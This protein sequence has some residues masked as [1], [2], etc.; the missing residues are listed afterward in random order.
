MGIALLRWYLV[1]WDGNKWV[2]NKATKKAFLKAIEDSNLKLTNGA[3]ETINE[4]K[5]KY[6]EEKT[7][8]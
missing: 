1:E 7:N 4:L 2:V 5:K 6:G 8:I 3:T